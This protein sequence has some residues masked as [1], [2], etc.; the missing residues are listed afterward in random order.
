MI[1]NELITSISIYGYLECLNV[2]P[3]CRTGNNCN[4]VRQF[5]SIL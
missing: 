2:L 4:L 3:H 1:G 5:L